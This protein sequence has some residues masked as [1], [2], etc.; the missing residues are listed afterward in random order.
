MR[1]RFLPFEILHEDDELIVIDKPVGLLTT[2]TR[3]RG[4]AGREAQPT[5]E[6]FLNR[7]VRKGQLKSTRSVALVHRLD[8]ETSGVIMFAKSA[9]LAERI[10]ERWAQLTAKT[11]LARVEGELA[12][13]EGV[14]DAPLKE[15]ADGYRVRVVE[16]ATPGAKAAR[17][18]WRRLAVGGGTTLVEVKLLTG[19]K[20]QIRVH[21]AAAG[22]PVVGDV[23]YGAKKAARL[24]LHAARLEFTHP[25][26][27]RRFGFCARPPDFAAAPRSVRASRRARLAALTAAALTALSLS[28]ATGDFERVWSHRFVFEG[29][30]PLPAG[31]FLPAAHYSAQVERLPAAMRFMRGDEVVA[32]FAAPADVT[33]PYRMHLMVTG[34]HRPAVLVTKAARTELVEIGD[35]PRGFDPRC[36]RWRE[37][38]RFTVT[39]GMTE[40]TAALS[41]GIGQADVRFVTRGRSNAP[42]LEDGRLYFT[43]S[44]RGYGAYLGVM[45][46]DPAALDF[47]YEGTILFD[48]GDGLLRNDVAADLFLDDDGVWRAWV[49]NFSTAADDLKGRREG[50]INCAFADGCPLRG[51]SVMRAKPLGLSGMYEDPD[52]YW[53]AA[54]GKWRLFVSEFTPLG[55]RA[56]MLESDRWDG[57]FRRLAGPTPADATGTTI[58]RVHGC[59][60]ALFGCGGRAFQI[61]E[62]PSLKPTGGQLTL[63]S[64]PWSEPNWTATRVWPAYL[65]LADGSEI[66]LTFDRENFPRM[67]A[68]NWTYGGLYLYRRGPVR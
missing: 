31:T 48:Y 6:N 52:G 27:G 30:L 25:V 50:G 16:A 34:A 8:R 33:P 37:E 43:F 14:F 63:S 28:G 4:R 42:Y 51:F 67:P 59:W 24:M 12:E 5:A 54:A 39:E 44:A 3:V 10:R 9:A 18:A 55:I 53:D 29:D 13:A 19:R 38:L 32:A 41:A 26:S 65:E 11:Y 66:I 49:C 61:A 17:T 56:S 64:P 45:S 35:W 2:H 57:G 22:H 60:R 58:A 23:K 20:N 46:F 7:Y 68:P 15:D 21:F 36:R 40:A 1:S 62:Y 47:R